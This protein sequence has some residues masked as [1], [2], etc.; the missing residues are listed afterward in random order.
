MKGRLVNERQA[1]KAAG[2]D[3]ETFRLAYVPV[4][5]VVTT[6]LGRNKLYFLKEVVGRT[7]AYKMCG[8]DP[9]EPYRS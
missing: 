3:V 7:E 2:C 8:A 5:H 9:Y 1:A 4:I 6:P